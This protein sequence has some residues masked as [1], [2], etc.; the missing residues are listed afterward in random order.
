MPSPECA[1]LDMSGLQSSE[2]TASR[3]CLSTNCRHKEYEPAQ[4]GNRIA[5]FCSG[6]DEIGVQI[7][8][9]IEIMFEIFIVVAILDGD[10]LGLHR[11]IL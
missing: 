6:G 8:M 7:Q 5:S 9:I 3:T 4:H 11:V 2:G 1:S 10:V